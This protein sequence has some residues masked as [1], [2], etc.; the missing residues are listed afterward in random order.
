MYKVVSKILAKRLKCVLPKLID[1]CQSAFLGGRNMLD[2]VLIANEV[3][4]DTKRRGV[5][6]LVFKVDYEKAYDSV[7]WSFLFYMLERMNFD[8]K[9][10]SWIRGCLYSSTVSVLVNG[11]PTEEFKMVKGL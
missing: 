9:W 6:T 7:R 11:C 2:N 3:V 8:Y 4:H 10:I 5:P 1:E